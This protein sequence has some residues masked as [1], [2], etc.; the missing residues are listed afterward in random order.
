MTLEQYKNAIEAS[1]IVSKTDIHGVITYVND[2]FCK[3]SEYSKDE[4]IGK[5]HN[6]I[7]HPD[8]PP[9]LYEEMWNTIK[10]DKQIYKGIVRNKSKNNKVFY[11]NTTIK[12]ILDEHNEIQ[13]YIALRDDVTDMM[14]PLKR[15]YDYVETQKNVLLILIK[16]ESYD[17][18]IKLYGHTIA[19]DIEKKIAELL[20]EEIPK[21]FQFD[22]IYILGDGEYAF[23][24]EYAECFQTMQE[25]EKELKEYQQ[26]IYNA[27]VE[28]Q[29]ISYDVSILISVAFGEN[30]IENTKL[31]MKHILTTKQQFIVANDFMRQEHEKAKKNVQTMKKVKHALE[32]DKIVS[33]FQP[34]INN[35]TQIIEKYESLVRLIEDDGKVLSPFFFL[36]LSKKGRYYSQI[37]SRVLEKSFKALESTQKDISINLSALDI[38]KKFTREK[39]FEL[40]HQHIHNASRVVFELLEDENVKDFEVISSF[41]MS[42]KKL[43]VKI[44]IDD[45]GAGYSNFERLLDYQPDILKIDACLIKDIVTDSYALSVVK[46][47]VRFTKEQNIKTVAEYVENEDI[48]NILKEIGIDYSQGYYFG[49]PEPLT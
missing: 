40:L 27:V 14:S 17:E 1:N 49:K 46:T 18:L 5:D 4:L 43:G 3:I 24:K 12:P 13:E 22:K 20:E 34:I 48:Y 41:I 8:N 19:D 16:I 35:E 37:T 32:N 28:V 15:L 47:I 7:R 10:V 11:L 30:V 9:S 44:A 25:I 26:T 36:G 39:I 33:Y 45:F 23:A 42:V 21:K 38:E 31:G 29:E 2:A 6:I